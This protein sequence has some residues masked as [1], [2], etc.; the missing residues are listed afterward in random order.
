MTTQTGIEVELFG[1]DGNAFALIGR[2]SRTLKQN[3]EQDAA[4]EFTAAAYDCD[5]YDE[6]LR[7]IM[8]TVVVA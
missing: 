1:C 4:K 6:L 2:V 7:L 5:S 3:G 8:S